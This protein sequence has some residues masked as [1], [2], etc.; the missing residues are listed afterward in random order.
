[1]DANQ[2]LKSDHKT[3]KGLVEVLTETTSRAANERTP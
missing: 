2:M 3:V 1:M